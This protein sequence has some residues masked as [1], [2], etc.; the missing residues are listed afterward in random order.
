MIVSPS[1]LHLHRNRECSQRSV[2][3][4]KPNTV[5][6]SYPNKHRTHLF[7]KCWKEA[8]GGWKTE[9]RR[10]I[11]VFRK[12][13]NNCI[14]A[15]TERQFPS[16]EWVGVNL[17]PKGNVRCSLTCSAAVKLEKTCPLPLV[18]SPCKETQP[19]MGAEM[20]LTAESW[21]GSMCAL[22]VYSRKDMFLQGGKKMKR[23]D[24]SSI[25]LAV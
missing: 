8:R 4:Q 24:S 3:A 20:I 16:A 10:W 6:E 19:S 11:D 17:L 23:C 22:R 15:R 21:Q 25:V 14:L 2:L 9:K 13:K 18:L 1:S 5:V 12:N 7:V